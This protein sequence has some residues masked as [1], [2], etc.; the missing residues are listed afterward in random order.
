MRANVPKTMAEKR[1]SAPPISNDRAGASRS[2]GGMTRAAKRI[3]IIPIGMLTRNIQCHERT[4]VMTPPIAGPA[5]KPME[6]VAAMTPRAMPSMWAGRWRTQMSGDTA[7]IIEA[8]APCTSRA[9]SSTSS[10]GAIPQA[11]EPS[12][13][14]KNPRR[15]TRLM[16]PRSAIFPKTRRS[17]AIISR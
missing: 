17:P 8:P 3:P 6:A 12:V 16:N 11:R 10:D 9:A 1:R 4:S 5:A 2:S 15:K 13:K 7:A 14:M